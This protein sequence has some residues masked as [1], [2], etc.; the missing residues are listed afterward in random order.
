MNFFRRILEKPWLPQ[1]ETVVEMRTGY[2]AVHN[3]KVAL[4]LFLCI[5]GILF[6]LLFVAYHMRLGMG[7]DWVSTPEPPLLWINTLVLIVVS[8]VFEWSRSAI[9]NGD[10]KAGKLRYIFVG[11]LTLVFLVLQLVVWQQLL[12]YGYAARANPSNAF[13]YMITAVHGIHLL[14]GL[15]AWA[16]TYRRFQLEEQNQASV[17][18]GVDLCALYWHFLLFVWIVMLALFIST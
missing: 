4:V 14:G 13:F 11:F 12:D 17:K 10:L 16:R 5:V 1:D 6:F 7:T 9:S 3:R 8:V 15:I 18:L 2:F